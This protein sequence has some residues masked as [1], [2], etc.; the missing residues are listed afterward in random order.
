MQIGMVPHAAAVAADVDD[1]TVM[2]EAIDQRRRHDVVAEDLA[3]RLETLVRRQH[4]RRVFVPP[5]HEL[6]EEHRARAIDREVADLVDDQERRKAEC[7]HAVQEPAGKLRFFERRDEIAQR[8]VVDAPTALRRSDGQAD[9][10]VRLADAGRSQED[11]VLLSLA[12][13]VS[14]GSRAPSCCYIPRPA[15]IPALPATL[16]AATRDVVPLQPISRAHIF[17]HSS[18]EAVSGRTLAINNC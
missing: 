2:H 3:P 8:A 16:F 15:A 4:G 10:Q 9:C 17:P 1:V 11:D 6:E 12:R 14:P 7:L 5:G 13:P 18:P